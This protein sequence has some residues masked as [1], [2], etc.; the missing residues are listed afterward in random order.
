MNALVW[1]RSDLRV[2]DNPA[3]RHAFNESDSVEAI[4]IYSNKQLKNH[5]EACKD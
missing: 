3:L 4:F 2:E 5:N 1:F